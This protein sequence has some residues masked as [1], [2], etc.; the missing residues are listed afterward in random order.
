MG[1]CGQGGQKA[2]ERREGGWALRAGGCGGFL[3]RPWRAGG[4]AA[5]LSRH[6]RAVG[7]C[8]PVGRCPRGDR[9][10]RRVGGVLAE[11]ARKRRARKDLLSN[12]A[13]IR[14]LRVPPSLL[15]HRPEQRGPCPVCGA[16]QGRGVRSVLPAR[17]GRRCLLPADGSA[18]GF[19]YISLKTFL[20][21]SGKPRWSGGGWCR[22]VLG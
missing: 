6:G 20:S 22:G 14:F 2:P 19:I 1:R 13:A 5:L 18:V 8:P 21:V 11:G 4:C 9:V 3:S 10:G 12:S 17:R 15:S 7:T 16:R